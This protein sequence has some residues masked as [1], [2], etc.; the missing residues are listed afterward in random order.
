MAEVLEELLSRDDARIAA[1]AA[2]LDDL[3]LE[4]Y[5]DRLA[6][7][8]GDRSA[9]ARRL[10]AGH[11]LAL[12]GDPRI[13]LDEPAT[14]VVPAGEALLGEVPR[15]EHVNVYA[16]GRYPVTKAEYARFLAEAHL[17]AP[18]LWGHRAPPKERANHPV[19]G[20]S[21]ADAVAYCRW[22][23]RRTG[24]TYR[25][26]DEREWEKAARGQSAR[27]WPWGEEAPDGRANTRE[28]GLGATAPVGAFPGGSTSE[29]L[30]DLVGN[31]RE[32]TN[33]WSAD[34]RVLRGGSYADAADEA[35]P[36]RRLFA[37]GDLRGVG[38][39]LVHGMTG[40]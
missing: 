35:R 3:G 5:R 15:A 9:L 21:W 18:P 20:V 33:T 6:E 34:G 14:I 1:A 28:S 40:R 25:L 8:L 23:T 12:L 27:S 16:I 10:A 11:A 22:L 26:P 13:R 30:A 7:A 24:R 31:V 32:W 38:F 19:E 4:A 36:S 2:A 37:T 17:P 39:R 29:G